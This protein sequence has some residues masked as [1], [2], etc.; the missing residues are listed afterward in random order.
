VNAIEISRDGR[1]FVSG[2]SDRGDDDIPMTG[3]IWRP[4]SLRSIILIPTG[5][6]GRY[7]SV[8]CLAISPDTKLVAA[9]YHDHVVRVFDRRKGHLLEELHGH[10]GDVN[11]IAFTPDGLGLIS[12][13]DD[14]TLKHWD[15]SRFLRHPDRKEPLQIRYR[16]R[17]ISPFV[18]KD[19]VIEGGSGE[20]GTECT[21]DFVG[22]RNFVQGVAV[23]NDNS[24]VVSGGDDR[25]VR[26]WDSST[27]ETLMLLRGHKDNSEFTHA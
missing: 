26:F 12:G 17:S 22:H 5:Q 24:W 23:S 16:L 2:S 6:Y 19:A 8:I 25:E 18:T 13:S 1:F 10:T 4:K 21:L 20:R 9:G 14:R 11:C 27:A 7:A 3:V 15:L